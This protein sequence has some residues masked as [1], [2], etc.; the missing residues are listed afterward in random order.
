[1]PTISFRWAGLGGHEDEAVRG[2]RESIVYSLIL[3][4]IL[5]QLLA[6]TK[7]QGIVNVRLEANLLGI[8]EK[9]V[10]FLANLDRASAEL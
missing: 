8:A 5:Q 10:L 3:A 9:G 7:V 4:K 1:M 2:L 6:M